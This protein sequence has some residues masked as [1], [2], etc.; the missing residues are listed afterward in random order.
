MVFKNKLAP[1]IPDATP[2][3]NHTLNGANR[4]RQAVNE[5]IERATKQPAFSLAFSHP[6]LSLGLSR[7]YM[8]THMVRHFLSLSPSLSASF[9]SNL[10][11]P[12]NK[13]RQS[14]S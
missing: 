11:L 6:S 14:L 2:A 12:L 7:Y 10:S 1:S 5:G 8:T 3:K 4:N 13:R 9:V